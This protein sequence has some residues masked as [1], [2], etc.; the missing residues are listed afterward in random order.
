MFKKIALGT[1]IF[2][3]GACNNEVVYTPKPRTYP[4]IIFPE[5]TY[6]KFDKDY[7]NF[8]FEYPTYAT[9]R[10]DRDFL[11]EAAKHPCWFDVVIPNLNG[12]VHCTYYPIK[13]KKHF[14]ELVGDAFE[15]VYK[16]NIRADYIEDYPFKKSKDV[17]GFVFN[18]KGPSATPF[19]FY[20]TDSTQHFIRGALY[21]KTQTRP[22]SLAPVIDFV[23]KDVVNMMNTFEWEE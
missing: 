9:I 16:H 23:K 1:L 13:D 15:L 18:F 21:F 14:E 2:L 12:R 6:Q 4:R 7:C 10:Q 5:R 11:N 17:S 8:T 22:D 20:L 19:Q 3:I